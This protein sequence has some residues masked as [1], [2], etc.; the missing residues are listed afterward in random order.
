VKLTSRAALAA[1][2]AITAGTAALL[3]FS[4]PALASATPP[5]PNSA[6]IGTWANTNPATRNV[7][8][9][10]V[11]RNAGGIAVDGFGACSPTSCEWGSIPGTVFGAT[12]SSATGNSF[13]AN[14]NFGFSRTVLLASLTRPRGAPM[15]LVVQEFTTFIPP[16]GRAN[17]TVTEKFVRTKKSI[18]PQAKGK[19]ATDYPRGDWVKPVKTLVGTWKN[20]SPT[21]GSITEIKLGRN[22]DGSLS[23]HA[24]GNCS[25]TLCNW[26]VVRGITFGTGIT[27]VSGRVFLAPYTFAFKKALLSGSLNNRATTLTVQTNS[28]FTDHS[29][30]SNYLVTDTFIRA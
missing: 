13:E 14:W 7:A 15:T 28:E 9:I 11:T 6:L 21:G 22:P 1:L 2:V 12:V 20:T 29:G 10:V 27:S 5:A 24:F 18:R 4:A 8:D 3:P 30:R 25:P 19:A 26:G 17:Y 16:D 23:V